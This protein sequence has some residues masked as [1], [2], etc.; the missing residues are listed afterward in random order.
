MYP[1]RRAVMY[2]QSRRAVMYSRREGCD[3]FPERE[4]KP[5]TGR[6][7]FCGFRKAGG[8]HSRGDQNVDG[9]ASPVQ[10]ISTVQNKLMVL[11]EIAKMLS[12]LSDAKSRA[13]R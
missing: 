1:D 4:Q 2:S 8:G 12:C 11:T 7:L 6:E 5:T 3:V 10:H 9:K 13:L